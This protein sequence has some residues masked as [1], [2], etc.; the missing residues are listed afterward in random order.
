MAKRS[1]G[2]DAEVKFVSCFVIPGNPAKAGRP[3]IQ[4]FREFWIT[5]R[6]RK[7]ECGYLTYVIPA[8]RWIHART[9]R[10]TGFPPARE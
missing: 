8:E 3:G 2:H 1:D 4:D 10:T 5:A 7:N 9:G 6:M